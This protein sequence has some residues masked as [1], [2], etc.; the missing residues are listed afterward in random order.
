MT[1]KLGT[2]GSEL[3][4]TQSGHVAD[5]LR[6]AGHDVELVTIRS[7]GDVTTGSLLDA[8]GLGL[9]A[10]ALRVALLA[11]QVD[12]VVHSLKDLPTA[13][14]PGLTVAAITSPRRCT[15]KSTSIS[16]MLTRSGL[17]KRSK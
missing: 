1:L 2:R 5:A 16:G 14:V 15:Q 10:A 11:G 13:P 6:A 3:A 4:R 12:L 17:R 7:E 9:F 8:G